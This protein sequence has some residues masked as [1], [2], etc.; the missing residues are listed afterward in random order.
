MLSRAEWVRTAL[1]GASVVLIAGVSVFA[2]RGLG[3]LVEAQDWVEHTVT[4]IDHLDR[5]RAGLRQAEVGVSSYALSRNEDDLRSY[6]DGARSMRDELK[7]LRALTADNESQVRR[8]DTLDPLVTARLESLAKLVDARRADSS[9]LGT[10]VAELSPRAASSL[11]MGALIAQMSDEENRLYGLRVE[12]ARTM[13]TRARFLIIFGPAIGLLVIGATVY[14]ISVEAR[15]RRLAELRLLQA[16]ATLEERVT[17]RT[18]E[19]ARQLKQIEAQA[20]DLE[21]ANQ[22]LAEFAYVASHDLQ[23]PL[24]KIAV[25]SGLIE[26]AIAK[27]D[28]DEV[29]R[30]TGVIASS[31]VRARRL[32]DNLLTFSRAT[33]SETHAQPLDLRAEVEIVLSDLSAAIEETGAQVS[34]DIPPVTVPADRTQLG[35]LIQN[36]VSNA[37]KYHK[38]GASPAI[39][40]RAAPAGAARVMLSIT[41]KGIGF[42][43][44]FAGEIFQPFKRLAGTTQYAGTGIGLAI[45]K[46]IADRYGWTIGVRSRPG[47]GATFTVALPTVG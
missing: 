23:E 21:I 26:E 24:R 20:D 33:S 17:E 31:A 42:D 47:Q 44:N 11:Q 4:V 1:I 10:Y 36:I 7:Q 18:A 12:A 19:I 43:E 46:T 39:D 22:R 34:V 15:R 38:P 8:L 9:A 40:I 32:V 2:Y 13:A 3:A 16:N 25:Y 5:L 37:I 27:S 6:T 35:R 29:A 28:Q 41:D 45:C 30:A 14:G